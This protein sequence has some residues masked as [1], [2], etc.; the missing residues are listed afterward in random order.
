[1]ADYFTQQNPPES[2]SSLKDLTGW[3]QDNASLGYYNANNYQQDQ[4]QAAQ[5]AKQDSM[6]WYNTAVQ[7]MQGQYQDLNNQ[8]AGGQNQQNNWYQQAAN[9]YST[10]E[11]PQAY[12]NYLQQ[13]R[14]A[15]MDNVISDMNKYY[16][17]RGGNMIEQLSG[18]GVLDSTIAGNALNNF[19][20]EQMRQLNNAGNQLNS[21]MYGQL[22]EAPMQYGNNLANLAQQYGNSMRGNVGTQAQ[23]GA[24]IPNA[25]APLYNM[26]GG[27]YDI[28]SAMSGQYQDAL[29]NLWG[30]LLSSGTAIETANIAADTGDSS[31]GV[32]D[33]INGLFSIGSALI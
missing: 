33:F 3:M 25:I 26:A 14:D 29:T 30:N 10:G 1:M 20:S 18:R 19:E 7:G 9:A 6:N 31:G 23:L 21:Q 24:K 11:A 17:Q 13:S 28:P 12:Q 15:M 5:Q 4:G 2:G 22:A 27:M 8:L 32:G 16:Q